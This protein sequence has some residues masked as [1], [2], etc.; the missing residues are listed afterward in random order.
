[1][2]P[3]T[4]LYKY[5][6]LN[7]YSLSALTNCSLW[8]SGFDRLNDP[9]ESTYEFSPE[10]IFSYSAKVRAAEDT[11]MAIVKSS[12]VCSFTRIPPIGADQ[13][14]ESSLMWSHYAAQFSGVCIEF[15]YDILIESLKKQPEVDLICQNV[16]YTP[17]AHKVNKPNEAYELDVMFK[18]HKAWSYEKE[19]RIVNTKTGNDRLHTYSSNA[20]KSIYIGGRMSREEIK[21]IKVIRNSI[22][23]KINLL[24]VD[25]SNQGYLFELRDLDFD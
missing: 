22:N 23:D 21:L 6:P 13:F 25:V 8:F 15:D 20:I 3:S 9:F 12:G 16:I 18:K 2:V 11:I 24:H 17:Y 1:M 5:Q 7:L 19:F 4:S 14:R 10:M